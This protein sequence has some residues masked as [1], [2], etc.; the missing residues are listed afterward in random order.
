MST[1]YVKRCDRCGFEDERKPDLMASL[2][3][4]IGWLRIEF[5][6]TFGMKDLCPSCV[7]ILKEWIENG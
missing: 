5:P 2:L 3:F 4:G 7:A 1:M 6:I